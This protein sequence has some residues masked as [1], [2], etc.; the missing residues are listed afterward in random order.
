MKKFRFKA[1]LLLCLSFSLYAN[2]NTLEIEK[3][4]AQVELLSKKVELRSEDT[5]LSVGG[6]I[7]LQSISASPDGSFYAGSIPLKNSS[8]AE[9]NQ[10][11]MSARESRLW[12]KT[13]TPSEHGP[14]RALV[15]MD[16]LGVAG[17]EVYSN[18]HGPRMR[19]AY[20]EAFGFTFGQTNST[21]NSYVT[22]D[23]ITYAMNN[24]LVRQPLVRYTIDDNAL[25]YDIAFEQPESTLLDPNGTSIIPKDDKVPDMVTRVRYFSSL[26]EGSIAFLAR[27]ITQND[28]KLSDGNSVNSSSSALGWGVNLSIKMK[29]NAL[30]DIRFDV[31]YGDGMGRY[32]AYNAYTAGSI[33]NEGEIKLQ[34]SYGAHI[35]YRHWWSK[36]LRSTLAL[37]YA[38]SKN[39]LEEINLVA[40]K[41]INRDA[42]ASQAN[43]LW[44]PISNLLVGIEH[45]RAIRHVENE[46]IGELDMLTLIVRY[47][48]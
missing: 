11:T 9:Y 6:R 4:K 27:Y 19:H 45:S 47:D 39:N 10:F 8:K 13:R 24:T 14:I 38:G 23:T 26:T 21:F 30:D 17:T 41:K 5:V 31:Q 33:N 28:V 43:L 16:F 20:V 32:F 37:S 46:D 34:T 15:E 2:E 3:L 48:F 29:T 1:F 35:A 36:K 12:I 7:E 42:Y 44:T 18:S 40:L 22:L 25:S